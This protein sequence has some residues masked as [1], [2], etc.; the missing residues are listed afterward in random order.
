[1]DTD[2]AQEAINSALAGDWKKA[3]EINSLIIE[4]NPQDID[5]LNRIARAYA[6]IGNLTKARS[7][8]HNVLKIDPFNSIANKASEKW[9]GLKKGDTYASRP[10]TPNLFLEEPGKTKIVS[11]LFLGSPKILA[12]LDSGDEVL[13]NTHSHRVSI[14][15][16]D[17]KYIGRLPDSL[18]ARLRQMIQLGNE[19][20]AFVKSSD[21]N[22]IKIFI[23]EVK[24]ADK[25]AKLPS[26]SSEKI[27]YIS[28]TP[29]ELVHRKEEMNVV[30]LEED[31]I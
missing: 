4:N 11:L 22:D 9:K 19:Y 24:R 25:L 1:M 27:D 5:A 23:R 10:L 8:A 21:K 29:P 30:N 20:I 28:F 13:L 18:S 12:K 6:E 17:G 2:L 3:I 31:D 15:T 16:T 26:F 14:D 7:C